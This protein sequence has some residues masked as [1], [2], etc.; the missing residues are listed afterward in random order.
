MKKYRCIKIVEAEPK[1]FD[2]ELAERFPKADAKIGDEGYKVRYEE[3]YESWSPKE[4]FEKGYVSLSEDVGETPL[5]PYQK[6]LLN[7]FVE[8]YDKIDK[9]RNALTK[10]FA[11]KIG[12]E[13]YNLMDA[14]LKAM[15][16][17]GFILTERMSLEGFSS[18]EKN[19]YFKGVVVH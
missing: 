3:G 7:D 12:A 10:E 18:D 19:I 9:L 11:E 14:Q 16:V 2:K 15:Q 8:L 4:V 1:K 5:Q 17:Y 6:R 13:K